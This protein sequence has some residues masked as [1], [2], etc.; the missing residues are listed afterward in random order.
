[1]M[2]INGI[3]SY[4]EEMNYIV[5]REVEVGEFWFWGAWNDR[6]EANTIAEEIGGVVFERESL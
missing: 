3:P 1:M 6:N 5:C 4:A 2:N